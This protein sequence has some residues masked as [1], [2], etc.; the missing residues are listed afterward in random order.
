MTVAQDGLDEV[1]TLRVVRDYL[2]EAA[3]A[4]SKRQA[5]PGPKARRTAEQQREED[6]R[7]DAAAT[8]ALQQALSMEKAHRW[9]DWDDALDR[10]EERAARHSAIA[11][12]AARN[13]IRKWASEAMEGSMKAGHI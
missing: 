6:S 1:Q 13:G 9:V 4:G 10:V 12:R 7:L 11:W 2:R 3:A 8:R 5:A